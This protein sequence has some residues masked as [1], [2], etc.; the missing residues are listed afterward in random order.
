MNRNFNLQRSFFSCANE[1]SA[2]IR[3]IRQTSANFRS[4]WIIDSFV[5]TRLFSAKQQQQQ[6]KKHRT[7]GAKHEEKKNVKIRA[8]NFQFS[9]VFV[10]ARKTLLDLAKHSFYFLLLFQ[11]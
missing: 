9:L 7:N 2:N 3:S 6:P 10:C 1:T 8:K 5:F 4:L 11:F